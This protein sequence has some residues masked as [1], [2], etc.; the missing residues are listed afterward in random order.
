VF[1]KQL[2]RIL[3]ATVPPAVTSPYAAATPPPGES[4]TT[5]IRGN[6]SQPGQAAPATAQAGYQYDPHADTQTWS[7]RPQYQ[8]DPHAET[9]TWSPQP[10]E[11]TPGPAAATPGQDRKMAPGE[12][13]DALR[14]VDQ[15][16]SDHYANMPVAQKIDTALQKALSGEKIAYRALRDISTVDRKVDQAV[17]DLHGKLDQLNGGKT[18]VDNSQSIWDEGDPESIFGY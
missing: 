16:R 4:P 13:G 10:A 12:M 9:Q 11:S 15:I 17:K 1:H 2:E 5:N 3:E 18:A 14:T 8:Y 6:Y 7:P